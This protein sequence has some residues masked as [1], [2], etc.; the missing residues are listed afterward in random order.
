MLA[1]Q[2][3][4]EPQELLVH[5]ASPEQLLNKGHL[6]SQVPQVQQEPQVLGSQVQQAQLV[7]WLVLL[8]QQGQ[9]ANQAL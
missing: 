3:L 1:P 5:K 4:R 9:L 8:V 6:A 7:Q 2:E